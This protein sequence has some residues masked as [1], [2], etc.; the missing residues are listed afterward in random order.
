MN[1]T[2]NTTF[3]TDAEFREQQDGEQTGEWPQQPQEQHGHV[4]DV[5]QQPVWLGLGS[6]YWE[7]MLPFWAMMWYNDKF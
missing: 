4:P 7:E 2:K 1:N 6:V 3:Q 5:L